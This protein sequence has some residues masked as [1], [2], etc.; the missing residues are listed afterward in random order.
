MSSSQYEPVFCE[1]KCGLKILR[2]FVTTH[3]MNE[4][5]KRLVAYR[6]CQE[7]VYDTLQGGN[8]TS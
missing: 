7:F 1:N 3:Q 5:T 2:R 6:Y 4:C 8:V